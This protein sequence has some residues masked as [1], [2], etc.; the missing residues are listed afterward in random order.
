MTHQYVFSLVN[1]PFPFTKLAAA[2]ALALPI[3]VFGADKLDANGESV[4]VIGQAYENSG[5]YSYAVRA[6]NGGTILAENITANGHGYAGG[7]LQSQGVGSSITIN[8]GSITTDGQAGHAVSAAYD[9]LV[10]LDG[11]DIQTTGNYSYGAYVLP[12]G[13]LNLSNVNI[14]T[15]ALSSKGVYAEGAGTRVDLESSSI[16]TAGD[17]SHGIE[18]TGV[19]AEAR[20]VDVVTA[21]DGAFGVHMMN[22]AFNFYNGNINTSGDS[23]GAFFVGRGGE[24]EI[25][26]SNL[27]TSGVSAHGLSIVDDSVINLSN[28]TVLVGGSDSSVLNSD[29]ST[30]QT[31]QFNI[32]DSVLRA[33]LGAAIHVGGDGHTAIN[34]SGS[35]IES[36]VGELFT[37]SASAGSSSLTAEASTLKGDIISG[38]AD[39][40]ADFNLKNGSTWTGAGNGI[41]TLSLINSSWLM[42]GDSTT[43]KVAMDGGSVSFDH[44]DGIY[45]TLT[46]GALSGNGR[47][48]MSTDLANLQGDMLVVQ[49]AGMATGNHQLLVSDSGHE[50]LNGDGRLKLVDTNG[51]DAKFDL[52]GGHVDA[53]AFRYGLEQDGDNWVLARASGKPA[54]ELSSGA[55][56]AVAAHTA[57]ASL[58]SAQMNALVKRLGELRMGKDEGGVWTR[59]I[60]KRYDVSENS[61]RAYTQNVTGI[62]IGADKAIALEKGKVYLGAMV[63]TASAKLNF[64]EGASGNTDS[65][66]VGVYAT[67]LNDNGVYVDSVLKH[68]QFDN[69]IKMSTNLGAP[70][71]GSYKTRGIGAD[72]EVGKHIKLGE[73]WFVEPQLELTAT[74]TQGGNYTASNGL[75]VKSDDVDSLQSRVGSLFG[76]SLEMSNGM[77]AQPYVKA[78]YVA[79]HAGSSKVSVNGNKIDAKLPG[80]R[81]ELGF[82]GVLQVSEKSKISLDAEYAKGNSIEQ[83]WG[84]NLGYRYLW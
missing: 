72:I 16:S 27:T 74:R 35:S 11:V 48:L 64:G 46:T 68:S 7:G 66:M 71:K 12:K 49:D 19:S 61:S 45:K 13:Q 1:M 43:R 80:N 55:N 75:R 26:N 4:E 24:A 79:E 84:V 76:R 58:W 18:F 2:C 42:S 37:S 17:V 10:V 57:S 36:V 65:K 47:F 14:T 29:I 83:P 20:D 25:S 8:G 22:S 62:E 15:T 59:G 5:T 28:S 9:G 73:G 3:S 60:S 50:P 67:Y 52:Y 77:K 78:S 40:D 70:V 69:D 6:I 51:G 32:S 34:L 21:G 44:S 33:E 41:D 63:G 39:F 53:G 54:E 30:G 81:V 82:G 56:A 23:S 38:S 31:G